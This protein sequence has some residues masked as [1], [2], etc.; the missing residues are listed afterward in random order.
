MLTG[1]A[2][3]NRTHERSDGNNPISMKSWAG[4]VQ[5]FTRPL[6]CGE[7][8]SRF[9]GLGDREQQA[10][11]GT[12]LGSNDDVR[13]ATRFIRQRNLYYCATAMQEYSARERHE[14]GP[15]VRRPRATV[16]L[17]CRF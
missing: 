7:L 14:Y 5:S 12:I 6:P 11:G 3:H 8:R 2:G 13:I 10:E 4:E 17:L 16:Q 1:G 9:V 15:F